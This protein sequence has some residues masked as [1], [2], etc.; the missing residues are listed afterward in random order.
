MA[1]TYTPIATVTLASIGELLFT[2]I[3]QIYTDLVI[4]LSVATPTTGLGGGMRYNGDSGNNYT[5]YQLRGD[6][7]SATSGVYS[8]DDTARIGGQQEFS[9]SIINVFDYASTNKYK[10]HLA[11]TGAGQAGYTW[12]MGGVWKNTNA[13]TQLAV[14]NINYPVG[15][16]ASLYG[17]KAA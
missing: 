3:P 11:R 2:N 8:V 9:T 12:I 1:S 17:I 13:I 16:T 7:S 14:Q 6:T 4:T 10:T 15:T 5:T